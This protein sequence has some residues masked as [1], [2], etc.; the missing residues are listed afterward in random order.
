[1]GRIY[2]KVNER[3][4][5][6]FL[7]E[8][9]SFCCGQ[10]YIGSIERG[11]LDDKYLKDVKKFKVYENFEIFLTDEFI[12]LCSDTE[13][14]ILCTIVNEE[15]KEILLKIGFKQI[16]EFVNCKTGN[17]VFNLQYIIDHGFIYSEDEED[18]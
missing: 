17:T 18:F 2:I 10:M 4:F 5:L 6:S 8:E 11:N 7:T 1:M 15:L 13:T 9:D 12:N 16:S 14:S 3:E